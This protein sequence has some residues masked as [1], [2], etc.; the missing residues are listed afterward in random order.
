MTSCIGCRIEK[1][2]TT[3][4]LSSHFSSS[5]RRQPS[6]AQVVDGSILAFSPSHILVLWSQPLES[7]PGLIKRYCGQA[8]VI[9]RLRWFV[10]LVVKEV[11]VGLPDEHFV[12]D[13]PIRETKKAWK[14]M[15]AP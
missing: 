4:S 13:V 14:S 6:E 12:E 15:V 8:P 1:V 7:K 10:I 2:T 5:P 11:T 3:V 9:K